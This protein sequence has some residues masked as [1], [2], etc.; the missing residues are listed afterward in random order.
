MKHYRRPSMSPALAA[1]LSMAACA[2]GAPAATEDN[3]VAN[4]EPAPPEAGKPTR[5]LR[6]LVRNHP[7]R[8]IAFWKAS[9]PDALAAPLEQRSNRCPDALFEYMALDNELNGYSDRP[10]PA[11]LDASYLQ[12]IE[13]ALANLPPAIKALLEQRV[14]G[15]CFAEG[16]G[17]SA[18]TEPIR[19]ES[20]DNSGRRVAPGR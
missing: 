9:F 13:Q 4:V 17:A 3:P 1:L 6:A 8:D 15:T 2:H 14:V 5:D 7:I 18:Y 10:R 11:A 20:E 12:D 16:L 19:D